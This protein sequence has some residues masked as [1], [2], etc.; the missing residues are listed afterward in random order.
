MTCLT[1]ELD[2]LACNTTDKFAMIKEVNREEEQSKGVP[3]HIHYSITSL[4]D[5]TNRQ[6]AATAAPPNS[7]GEGQGF[8]PD[9]MAKKWLLACFEM[10][11]KGTVSKT[12]LYSGYHNY[13]K[14]VFQIQSSLGFMRLLEHIRHFFPRANLKK[15]IGADGKS[16]YCFLL[17]IF[18]ILLLIAIKHPF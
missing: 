2:S 14:N 1:R 10:C 16:R 4:Y 8:G 15:S 5:D 11:V 13:L 6:S 7:V 9:E 18:T 3:E 17:F 12:Q